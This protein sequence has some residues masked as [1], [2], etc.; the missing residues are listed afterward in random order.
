MFLK[1]TRAASSYSD[2][3]TLKTRA[4]FW[5]S[6]P[7]K[8]SVR[9]QVIALSVKIHILRMNFRRYPENRFLNKKGIL[10]TASRIKLTTLRIASDDKSHRYP[11][12]E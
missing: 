5:H 6:L 10:Q 8:F 2:N 7:R 12:S 1:R 3:E 9:Y 4:R 11:G